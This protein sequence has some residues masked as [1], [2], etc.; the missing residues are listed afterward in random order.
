M[1]LL[2]G[3]I[4]GIVSTSLGSHFRVLTDL[5]NGM[6]IRDPEQGQKGENVSP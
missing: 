5:T 4:K 2:I 3:R 1:I 6:S